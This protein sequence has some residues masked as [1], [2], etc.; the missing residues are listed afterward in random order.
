MI[1]RLDSGEIQGEFPSHHILH[2]K[3]AGKSLVLLT[4]RVHNE[5]TIPVAPAAALALCLPQLS[6]RERAFGFFRGE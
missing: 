6:D 4:P 5:R 3:E 2:V 1:T